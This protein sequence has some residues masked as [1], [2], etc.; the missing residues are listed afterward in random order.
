M[1][2]TIEAVQARLYEL[3]IT[4]GMKWKEIS[5]MLDFR[6]IP[7]GTLSAILHGREPKDPITRAKLNLAP[8][9]SCGQ[10]WRFNRFLKEAIRKPARWDDVPLSTLRVALKHREEI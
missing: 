1:Y 8:Y 4:R 5:A 3:K 7:E 10:C 2:M 6:G 9:E